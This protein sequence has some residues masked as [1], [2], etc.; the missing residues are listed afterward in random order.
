MPQAPRAYLDYNASAPLLPEAR[1]AVL[2]ALDQHGNASSVHREGRAQRR[3]IEDARQAVASL[4]GAR[5]DNVIFT[6]GATEAAMTAL[7]PHWMLGRGM[8]RY[9]R[10]LFGATEHPCV[11]AGGRFQVE[12]R[13]TL[14]VD[15]EGRIDLRGLETRLAEGPPALVAVQLANSETGVLQ[16]MA[17]IAGLVHDS[18]GFL[19]CDAAQAAG[20]VPLQLERLGADLLIVSA[21]KIGGP[22]GAGAL[23]HASDLQRPHNLLTGGG[24]EKSYRSGTENTV[25]IAGFGAAAAHAAASLGDREQI[26]MMR[27]RF[28][29]GLADICPEVVIHGRAAPRLDNTCYFTIPGRPAE[30][31]QIAFDLAGVA[32]SPGSACSSGKVAVSP[33][34]RAMGREPE[35]GAIRVSFGPDNSLAEVDRALAVLRSRTSMT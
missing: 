32:V 23:V 30:T 24:Q 6:S 31:L 3:I 18:G 21:H 33:V 1:N 35:E 17:T 29:A 15:G 19:V 26:G 16:D 10:L 27:D 20:R 13:I 7:T 25:A 8:L 9:E 14:G 22:K 12:Q 28:E 34:L 5:T 4:C 11:S 2:A